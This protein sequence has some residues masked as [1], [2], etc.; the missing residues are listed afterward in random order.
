MVQHHQT[1]VANREY[2]ARKWGGLPNEERFYLP[3]DDSRYGLRIAHGCV[4]VP[5]E[6]QNRTDFEIVRM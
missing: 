4:D 1:F 3:F 5:Y 2:Y 6:G